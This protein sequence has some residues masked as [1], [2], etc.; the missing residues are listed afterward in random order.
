[1]NDG[2]MLKQTT[3]WCCIHRLT[4]VFLKTFKTLSNLCWCA[5][6]SQLPALAVYLPFSQKEETIKPGL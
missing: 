2:S 6:L 3:H 5:T 4:L 1:M